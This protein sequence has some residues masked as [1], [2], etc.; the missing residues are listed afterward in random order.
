MLLSVA[1][2]AQLQASQSPPGSSVENLATSIRKGDIAA[3]ERAGASGDRAY[4]PVLRRVMNE[5][6]YRKM[7][8][9][10]ALHAQVALARLGDVDQLQE[11]WCVAAAD[12]AD[13]PIQ[14]IELLGGWYWIQSMRTILDGRARRGFEE[15]L[16][17]RKPTDVL[18]TP[19]DYLALKS[20]MEKMPSRPSG[21]P[22][23]IYVLSSAEVERL[24]DTWRRWIDDHQGELRVLEPTGA[25]VDW[26]PGAC[27]SGRPAKPKR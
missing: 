10:P 9:Q 24:K 27:K 13:V 7:K 3:I 17:T 25:G 18:V 21:L 22:S 26:S 2:S 23:N 16:R 1:W 15:S 20:L 4:I 11:F 5:K 12:G 8:T 6:K 14:Q 19:P